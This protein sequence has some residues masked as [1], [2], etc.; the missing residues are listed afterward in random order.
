MKESDLVARRLAERTGRWI[1]ATDY[2]QVPLEPLEGHVPPKATPNQFPAAR[3][4]VNA[5]MDNLLSLAGGCL[6]GGASAGACIVETVR[7]LRRDTRQP[8][9]AGLFWAMAR[10][11]PCSPRSI[12]RTREWRLVPGEWR[13]VLGIS[14]RHS[15]FTQ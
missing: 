6:I 14:S 1:R 9:A 3:D 10:S 11:M 12:H 4:D 2:R 13:L 7:L 5:A 8:N 15:S